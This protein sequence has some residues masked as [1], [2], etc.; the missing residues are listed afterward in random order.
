MTSYQ[1]SPLFSNMAEVLMKQATKYGEKKAYVY[2][3]NGEEDHYITYQELDFKARIIASY[4]QK[5]GI[6]PGDRALL[7]FPSGLDFIYTFF[8]CLYAKVIAVP[9]YPPNRHVDRLQSIAQDSKPK[10]VMTTSKIAKGMKTRLKSVA[11]FSSIPWALA[12]EIVLQ[13]SDEYQPVKIDQ[14]DIAFLQYTSGSTGN[15]KGVILSHNNLLFNVHILYTGSRGQDTWKIVTWLPMYHDMGMI[16]MVLLPLYMGAT[17]YMMS[18][19][20]FLQKPYLWLKAISQYRAEYSGAPNF[21]YDL[22]ISRISDKLVKT[23]DLSNWK[24][25]FSGAEPVRYHT[26]VQF[27]EKFSACHFQPQAFYPTFGLAEATLM[28]TGGD[29]EDLPFYH[30]VDAEA[31][32]EGRA[33]TATD[34]SKEVLHFVGCGQPWFDTEVRIVNPETKEECAEGEVG[35][36]WVK[37]STVAQGYWEKPQ[38]TQETFHAYIKNSK[39]G[40]FLRTGDLGYFYQDHLFIPGRLKEVIIIR[41]KNHYPS[42]IEYTVESSH[43]ALMKNASAAFSIEMKGEERLVVVAEVARN[44]YPAHRP[45]DLI[46][47]GMHSLDK[48]EVTRAVRQKVAEHHEVQVFD[49]VLIPQGHMMKTSSGKI[50]RRAM[51]QAYLEK[52]LQYW[53]E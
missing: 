19:V 6:Q 49:L 4:L 34:E 7:V 46:R 52:K 38:E 2:L 27:I 20:E 18:P 22:C 48:K 47:E 5:N 11:E 13:Y 32:K 43:P 17:C 44:Y 9:A 28:V 37:G 33:I 24:I 3:I 35:E 41:G 39:E 40:P 29:I 12:D 14:Q 15:P 26:V 50:Q 42:D 36:I 25:A 45:P 31:L 53:D 51:R 30:A 16:G 23:L 1:P 10:V 8:G 21:A